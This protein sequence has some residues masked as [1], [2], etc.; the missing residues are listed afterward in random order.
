M[1]PALSLDKLKPVHIFTHPVSSWPRVRRLGGERS[2]S[3]QT[4][5]P[6]V[7]GDCRGWGEVKNSGWRQNAKNVACGPEHR[8]PATTARYHLRICRVMAQGQS[9]RMSHINENLGPKVNSIQAL[10]NHRHYD[11][12]SHSPSEVFC[13]ALHRHGTTLSLTLMSAC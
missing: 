4:V 5:S 3:V 10:T 6:T 8:K 1:Q 12:L 7:E 11:L 13:E 2:R 9:Y